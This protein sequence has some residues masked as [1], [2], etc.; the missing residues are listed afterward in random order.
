MQ[1]L[2]VGTPT[3]VAWTGWLKDPQKDLF[4]RSY[5][6]LG[7]FAMLDQA[8]VDTWSRGSRT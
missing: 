5:D 4:G 7:F 8:G 1:E 6:G 3:Q 2:N